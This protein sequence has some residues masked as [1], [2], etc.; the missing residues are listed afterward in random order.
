M[1]YDRYWSAQHDI[2]LWS[3]LTWFLIDLNTQCCFNS[4]DYTKDDAL[5][6]KNYW[7]NPWIW[8]QFAIVTLDTKLYQF[9]STSTSAWRS[10][11]YW[12]PISHRR[13]VPHGETML[14]HLSDR[15][16]I[17]P[18]AGGVTSTNLGKAVDRGV[19]E[20]KVHDSWCANMSLGASEWILREIQR[21]QYIRD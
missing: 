18:I 9:V 20:S 2:S 7:D 1:N 12:S 11:P 21:I 8:S 19:K 6:V 13:R 4:H 14:R 3:A 10:P 17:V 15:R 5:W 16:T